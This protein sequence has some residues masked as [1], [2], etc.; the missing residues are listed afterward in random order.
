MRN[1]VD[2]SRV[3]S[4]W[5]SQIEGRLPEHVRAGARW[6]ELISST[7]NA[8]SAPLD[9]HRRRALL[10][11]WTWGRV[12]PLL[13]PIASASGIASWWVQ[14]LLKRSVESVRD[15]AWA[16]GARLEFEGSRALSEITELLNEGLS[17]AVDF[18]DTAAEVA[19]RVADVLDDPEAWSRMDPTGVL[20]SLISDREA[21]N[22][23]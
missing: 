21:Q 9:E 18:S 19:G 2:R 12:L 20:Q 16:A 14:M 22:V 8:G 7:T 1:E 13:S 11:E 17:D 23:D 10:L 3:I 5:V 15:A 4:G 6:R